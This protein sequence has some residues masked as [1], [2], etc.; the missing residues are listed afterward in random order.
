MPEVRMCSKSPSC[1][2]T[3][4]ILKIAHLRC[5]SCKTDARP[6]PCACIYSCYG[7]PRLCGKGSGRGSSCILVPEHRRGAGSLDCQI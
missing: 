3:Q 4:G 6:P 2:G 7:L 5:S 1:R